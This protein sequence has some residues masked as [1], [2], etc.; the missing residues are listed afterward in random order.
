ML[1][2]N[3]L[4]SGYTNKPILRDI[5]IQVNPGE[6]IV[7]IG[8]NGSGKTTLMRSLSGDIKAST[9]NVTINGQPISQMKTR[10]RA[11]WISVVPQAGT[12]PAGFSVEETVSFGRTP[13]LDIFGRISESDEQIAQAALAKVNALELRERMVGQLS[14][15]EQQRVLLARAIAQQTPIMLMDEPTTYLDLYFQVNFLGLVRRLAREDRKTIIL[16]LHDL[17]QAALIADRILL[18]DH[19]QVRAFGTPREVLRQDIISETYQLNVHITPI[20]D[21]PGFLI[22]PQQEE[23]HGTLT[24]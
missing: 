1:R 21:E 12:L 3:N 18:L 4:F 20:A 13:Y 22:T 10:E 9:G 16:A 24:G 19:G 7:V 14:G 8:P 15:G 17:N 2:A 5:N 11:R 6:V 23:Q